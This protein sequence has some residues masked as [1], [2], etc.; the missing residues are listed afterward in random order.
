MSD[1]K[2]QVIEP[3]EIIKKKKYDDIDLTKPGSTIETPYKH[4]DAR[5]KK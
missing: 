1:D 4:G 3:K 5:I 2:K